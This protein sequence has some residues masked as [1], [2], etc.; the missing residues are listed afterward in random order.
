MENSENRYYIGYE[1]H[2]LNEPI[3]I[4]INQL[5]QEYIIRYFQL[6][7][8][9]Q[10]NLK[11]VRSKSDDENT[12]IPVLCH[13]VSFKYYQENIKEKKNVVKKLI[14]L[15]KQ[16]EWVKGDVF[17]CHEGGIPAAVQFYMMQAAG[18][19]LDWYNSFKVAN[20]SSI[21]SK[22]AKDS[23]GNTSTMYRSI[24]AKKKKRK[25]SK[26]FSRKCKTMP[27][28]SK[29]TKEEETKEKNNL[30]LNFDCFN[31][32]DSQKASQT[33][34]LNDFFDENTII[35]IK[36]D[37]PLRRNKTV[38]NMTELSR[39][40]RNTVAEF[41]HNPFAQDIKLELDESSDTIMTPSSE[42]TTS[43]TPT[44]E[45]STNTLNKKS[46]VRYSK[47]L[48]Q[49]VKK[50]DKDTRLWIGYG[51]GLSESKPTTPMDH[52]PTI[53]EEYPS[54]KHKISV[55]KRPNH[56]PV[57]SF[58]MNT[59]FLEESPETGDVA[60]FKKDST[61]NKRIN[62]M[63]EIIEQEVSFGDSLE[64][65]RE[66]YRNPMKKLI[67][68]SL[69]NLCFKNVEVI[70]VVHLQVFSMIQSIVPNCKEI[71]NLSEEQFSKLIEGFCAVAPSFRLYCNYFEKLAHVL[72][73]LKETMKDKKFAS[74]LKKT[75]ESLKAKQC[76]RRTLTDFLQ[77][78]LQHV[79]R[80]RLIFCSMVSKSLDTSYE[81][82]LN[83]LVEQLNQTLE[84][85]NRK[86][87]AYD[88]LRLA[89]DLHARL[90]S[91]FNVCA[92]KR[93]LLVEPVRVIRFK[94]P[95][96]YYTGYLWIFSD[97]LIFED[98][99]R[100]H[101]SRHKLLLY[102]F[103]DL[104]WKSLPEP[105]QSSLLRKTKK[106]DRSLFI[107]CLTIQTNSNAYYFQFSNDNSI[108]EIIEAQKTYLSY[109]HRKTYAPEV[110]SGTIDPANP[111]HV[112]TT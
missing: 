22:S 24:Y 27:K 4:K 86:K 5:L 70:E 74:F 103:R 59:Q 43:T 46:N 25:R 14:V 18:E 31:H 6:K 77:Q 12:K 20:V 23:F 56:V 109:L 105:K 106:E 108:K 42:S 60:T 2:L 36:N 45:T 34:Q 76:R 21:H 7:D 93:H 48:E 47:N 26:S 32:S 63:L 1:S 54:P 99:D 8:V 67:P 64:L 98:R 94:P 101:K 95:S 51:F 49:D 92:R 79:T 71:T 39:T 73:Q 107:H 72:E 17:C 41:A 29:K 53:L 13:I 97:A 10:I 87:G 9:E 15:C 75:T 28:M 62:L 33:Q 68:S 104:S 65:L 102:P 84:F 91:H 3:K 90:Q 96:K 112:F 69:Y 83:T 44:S 11:T 85:L 82:S 50:Y 66:Y 52:I 19:K 38:G 40:R 100:P 111:S 78:P 57:D 81:S 30:L 16:D 58:E 35:D 80:Y 61:S 88:L 37:Q 110:S 55:K 89:F